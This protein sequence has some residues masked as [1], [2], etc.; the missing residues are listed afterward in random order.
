[1]K[2][3]Q[4]D[5]YLHKN[6]EYGEVD[7][8]IKDLQTKKKGIKD[9]L[10]G[11]R[12]AVLINEKLKEIKEELDSVEEAMFGSIAQHEITTG[13]QL[14]FLQDD[15]GRKFKLKKKYQYKE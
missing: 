12:S 5:E 14:S 13:Q 15:R 9:K 4:L 10:M 2:K 11:S 3:E 1:M 7:M 6:G 8:Q